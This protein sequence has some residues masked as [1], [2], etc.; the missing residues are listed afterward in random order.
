MTTATQTTE[1]TDVIHER[2]SIQIE[3]GQLSLSERNVRKT[4]T[5]KTD[6]KELQASIASQGVLQNLVVAPEGKNKFGVIAGGRRLKALH[7]LLAEKAVSKKYLVPC[8]IVED[9]SEIT[10][11]SL[12]ENITQLPMHPADQYEAFA[13][14][15]E[16][17]RAVGDIA[18]LYG[19]GKQTVAKRLKLGQV[20]PTILDAYRAGK[21]RHEE[22]MAYTVCED[23]EKQLACF[24]H[25]GQRAWSGAIKNWSLDEAVS[26][27]TGIGRFVGAAAYKKAGGAVSQ[28]L[29]DSKTYLM[30]TAL[31]HQLAEDKLAKVAKKL[32]KDEPSWLWVKSSLEA[33]QDSDFV[34]ELEPT[35][36][37][38]PEQL[39][40]SIAAV[41]AELEPLNEWSYGDLDNLSEGYTD[42]DSLYDRID[43]LE[44]ELDTLEEQRDTYLGHTDEQRAY[45]GCYVTLAHNGDIRIQRG[46]ANVND[47]PKATANDDGS[48]DGALDSTTVEPAEEG[49][50]LDYSKNLEAYL[51]QRRQHAGKA[52]LLKNPKLAQDLLLFF[53]CIQLIDGIGYRGGRFATSI[54]AHA[55][56]SETAAGDTKDDKAAEEIDAFRSS[57]NL[58]WAKHEDDGAAFEAFMSLSKR[59]KEKLG[60]FCAMAYWI[61]SKWTTAATGRQRRTTTSHGVPAS[62]CSQSLARCWVMIG[63]W[64]TKKPKKPT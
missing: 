1:H 32:H 11:V 23:H 12:A 17:G 3:L 52:T 9:A 21:I 45:S 25:C 13:Q 56:F 60:T 27:H 39:D 8:V 4:V 40:Q 51:K 24:K 44:R 22:V 29:F 46:I 7:A 37:D 18:A 61:G 58:S 62:N 36:I 33:R 53:Q 64:R 26:T 34:V 2:A 15:A 59:E 5:G 63:S 31:V 55:V 48:E 42:G 50:A 57:L 35:Y 14:L 19:V 49:V 30:D 6:D 20:T 16:Q 10:A 54:A 38:V 41:N 28:D 47:I 43:T